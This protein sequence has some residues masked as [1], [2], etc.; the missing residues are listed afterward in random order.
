MFV[1]FGSNIGKNFQT[2][3]V[4]KTEQQTEAKG[5]PAGKGGG[6][7]QQVCFTTCVLTVSLNPLPARTQPVVT[8]TGFKPSTPVFVSLHGDIYATY[9]TTDSNGA[10]SFVY[11]HKELYIPGSYTFVAYYSLDPKGAGVVAEYTFTV[12]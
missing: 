8:G 7:N 3:S 5:P 4:K 12:F 10:F 6:K 11:S 9:L 2:L 1:L